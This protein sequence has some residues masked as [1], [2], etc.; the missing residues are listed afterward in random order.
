MDVTII[1]ILEYIGYSRTHAKNL[2]RQGAIV[3]NPELKGT[4]SWAID[5]VK[6]ED[7]REWLIKKNGVSTDRQNIHPEVLERSE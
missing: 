5:E 7:I 6:L 4:P 2:V 1:D 3:R